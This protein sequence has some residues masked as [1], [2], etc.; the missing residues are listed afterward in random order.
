MPILDRWHEAKSLIWRDNESPR[1]PKSAVVKTY[2]I[3]TAGLVCIDYRRHVPAA[4]PKK[5]GRQDAYLL[6]HRREQAPRRWPGVATPSPVSGR[7][8]FL[9]GRGWAKGDRSFGGGCGAATDAGVVGGGA[10]RGRPRR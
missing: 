7:D 4:N 10:D 8:Q 2:P 1:R 5:E 3:S 6:E 9:A